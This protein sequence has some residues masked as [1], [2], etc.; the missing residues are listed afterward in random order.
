MPQFGDI[1]PRPNNAFRALCSPALYAISPPLC[2]AIRAEDADLPGKSRRRSYEGLKDSINIS[3][4]AGAGRCRSG[5]A[6][7]LRTGGSARR[8]ET[9]TGND[10]KP[11][12]IRGFGDILERRF[13]DRYNVELDILTGGTGKALEF[14]QAG[15]GGTPLPSM[16]ASGKKRSSPRGTGWSDIP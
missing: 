14:G 16:T 2:Y 9:E 12:R 6:A 13:E 4:K 11:V 10:H 3:G 8:G 5:R 1:S 15:R 7:C